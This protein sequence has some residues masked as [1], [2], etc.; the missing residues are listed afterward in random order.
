MVAG[1]T[2]NSRVAEKEIV[3]PP[4]PYPGLR[5]FLK[6]EWPIFFG[7]ESMTEDIIERLI[8]NQ[9][10]TVHGD[11]GCGKSSLIAAGVLPI[12][13]NDLARV[14]GSWRT[15]IVRPQDDP[16]G[17]LARGLSQTN[18]T[19]EGDYNAI[20]RLL[21]MG[22][23]APQKLAELLGCSASKNVCILFDQFEELFEHAKHDGEIDAELVTEFLVGLQQQKPMGFHVVLTMRSDYLGQCAQ[24]RGFAE[25]VN[26][27]QYLLPR[28]ERPALLRAI[29]E[30]AELFGGSIERLLA[31]RLITDAGSNQDQLPLLQHGLMLLWRKKTGGQKLASWTLRSEDYGLEGNLS[32]LLSQHADVVMQAIAPT[33]QDQKIVE[34]V[35]RA[36]SDQNSERQAIRRR[37]E[38]SE[39][40]SVSGATED[41]LQNLLLPFRADEVSFIRPFGAEQ[42]ARDDEVD[43]SHESILRHWR[44]I[45]DPAGGWL[46]REAEAG[47]RWALYRAAVVNFASNANEWLQP[48]SAE[49]GRAFL[50]DHNATWAQRYGGGW[51]TVNRLVEASV[52]HWDSKAREEKQG[53]EKHQRQARQLRQTSATLALVMLLGVGIIAFQVWQESQSR[54]RLIAEAAYAKSEQ[55]ELDSSMRLALLAIQ[56][57]RAGKGATWIQNQLMGAEAL[58]TRKRKRTDAKHFAFVALENAFLRTDQLSTLVG[59]ENSINS[60]AFSSDGTRVVTTSWDKTARIWDAATGKAVGSPLR[61]QAIVWSAVFSG[62]DTRI[63]TVSADVAKIFDTATGQSIGETLKHGG[64]IKSAVFSGDGTRIVTASSDNT[65]QIWDAATGKAMGDPLKHQDRVNSAIFSADGTRIVTASKD[66]TAQ[67][68]DVATGKSIGPP[69]KHDSSVVSAVFSR[70]G[71]RIVTVSAKMAQVWDA[72]NQQQI[73]APLEHDDSV[74]SAVFSWDSS[75]IV[76]ASFDNTAR[77][78][79]AATGNA[80]SEPLKHEGSVRSAVFSGDGRRIVTASADKTARLWD[81]D[82]GAAIG[83]PLKHEGSVKTAVFSGDGTRVVTA[84]SDLTA[85][86]WNVDDGKADLD[87]LQ[88][89]DIVR[90]ANF[91]GFGTRIV[92][93]SED[94]SVKIWFANTSKLISGPLLHN[95]KVLSALF[96]RDRTRIVTV[97]G[98]TAQI[99]DAVTGKTIGDSLRHQ[100]RVNS[101]FFSVDFQRVITASD[102]KTAQIWDAWSGKA[103]GSPLRHREIVTT[104]A[105]SS[106]GTQIVTASYDNTA[107]IWNSSTGLAI[108]GPLK[109]KR[110]VTSAVFSADGTRILTASAD[111]FAQ[112]WDAKTGKAIGNSMKHLDLVKSAVFSKDGTRVVT[113]SGNT[114]RIWDALTGQTIGDSLKHVNGV[115]SAIFSADGS[116]VVTSSDDNTAQIWDTATGKALG[117]P[118]RHKGSVNSAVFSFDD[119]FIVTA[120]ADMTARIWPAKPLVLDQ[121]P[122]LICARFFGNKVWPNENELLLVGMENEPGSNLCAD[123]VEAR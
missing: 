12:L 25:A 109:H 31:D 71:T 116:R 39:L 68:W 103:L 81:V 90:S 93:A 45:S 85:R 102:D 118:L 51:E 42:I 21:N 72:V 101:A 48:K 49:N 67:V 94:G 58:L 74:V 65:A 64:S 40:A 69:L 105:F 27:T 95:D 19:S 6:D 9:L 73:G 30:P 11:S 4:A 61:H 110:R 59:H 10:V 62:D 87:V 77:I 43:V 3:L 114:A 57:T 56:Q 54:G 104:A 83:D 115:N 47:L 32:D 82:T 108:G 96:S 99:W 112:I 92:T 60:A 33:P 75:R 50:A 89:G 66:K 35:F 119:R 20:R 122:R 84:S 17:N 37:V 15:F 16:L 13:E 7:R 34:S 14:G 29:N 80:I 88:H 117:N 121:L 18:N 53:I 1:A 44:K 41:Q 98:S 46:A 38:F 79:D 78:W 107:Q 23:N 28:M 106:D 36:L 2:M 97:S 24:Y 123:Y 26:A 120:S 5:P 91:S 55:G 70:D 8:N 22:K 52:E 63:V 76:T 113:V 100:G 111:K 86:I